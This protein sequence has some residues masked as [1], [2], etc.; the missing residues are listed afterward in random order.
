MKQFNLYAW[1]QNERDVADYVCGNH[2]QAIIDA[3]N[4]ITMGGLTIA[5]K[6][7]DA[8]QNIYLPQSMSVII[9][10][11]AVRHWVSSAGYNDKG[12]FVYTLS[13]HRLWN[14]VQNCKKR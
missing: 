10:A 11:D 1:L 9:A 14:R 13:N 3:N 6:L 4:G 7:V 8:W 2:V 5:E 12:K